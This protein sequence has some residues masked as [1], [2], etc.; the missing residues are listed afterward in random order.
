MRLKNLCHRATYIFVVLPNEH[1]IVQKR[2]TLKDYCPGYYDP[3]PG[4][5][6]GYEET[7]DLNAEREL[8]E[9][10]GLSTDL[11]KMF[12]FYY[13]D[14]EV[15]CWG[16]AYLTCYDG[17]I[18]DLSLQEEEVSGVEAMSVDEILEREENGEKFTKDSTH[19]VRLYKQWKEVREEEEQKYM[20]IY[21][22]SNVHKNHRTIKSPPPQ[23]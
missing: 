10:M 5:V 13:K 17:K 23:K 21:A 9:E 7:Y 15:N 3:T 6:V 1:L 8:N 22:S 20:C 18:D 11:Q 14:S 2:S 19:A 16:A 4:G 12:H